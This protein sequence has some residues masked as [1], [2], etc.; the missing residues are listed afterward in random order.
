[1]LSV[2]TL[3]FR[4]ENTFSQHFEQHQKQTGENEKEKQRT[5]TDYCC[6]FRFTTFELVEIGN[7][8]IIETRGHLNSASNVWNTA[9]SQNEFQGRL[10][11]LTHE[12]YKHPR[13]RS[14]PKCHVHADTIEPP[15]VRTEPQR[16][17]AESSV[18]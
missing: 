13:E 5:K 1:M 7:L 3:R 10:H 9:A 11:P 2:E 12:T 6:I 8:S 14:L 17:S 18:R 15:G 16:Q 4:K